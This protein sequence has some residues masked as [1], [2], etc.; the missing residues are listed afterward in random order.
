[1]ILSNPNLKSFYTIFFNDT[2]SPNGHTLPINDIHF[3]VH[4]N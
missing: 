3:L 2:S 4:F 1:M